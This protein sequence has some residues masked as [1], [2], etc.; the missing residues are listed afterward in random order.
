MFGEIGRYLLPMVL[1]RLNDGRYIAL[2]RYYKP[3]GTFSRDRLDYETSTGAFRFKR[4][5]TEQDASNMSFRG[6]T[7]LEAIVLYDEGSN[8]HTTPD[9]WLAYNR[10]LDYFMNLSVQL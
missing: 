3:V 7:N 10:R 6:D 1:Q 4:E 2:N 9:N 5:I 8:P